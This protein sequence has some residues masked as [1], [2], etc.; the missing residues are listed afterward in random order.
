MGN[1]L[2]NKARITTLRIFRL[3]DVIVFA[4]TPTQADDL[5]RHGDKWEKTLGRSAQVIKPTYGVVTHGVPIRLVN[6]MEKEAV[7]RKF[8]LENRRVLGSYRIVSWR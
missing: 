1:A 2:V 7:V 6:D 8:E 4:E 3:G 5:R